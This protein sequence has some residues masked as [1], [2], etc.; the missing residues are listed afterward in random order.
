MTNITRRARAER[1]SRVKAMKE[2]AQKGVSSFFPAPSSKS[3]CT[4]QLLSEREKAILAAEEAEL[5]SDTR[6]E[7][8]VM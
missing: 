7:C 4:L 5:G 3:D 8:N 1:I 2:R 6:G